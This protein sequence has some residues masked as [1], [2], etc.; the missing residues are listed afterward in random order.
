MTRLKTSMLEA[1]A[2]MALVLIPLVGCS[3][4]DTT[5]AGSGGTTAS[6]G[7]TSSGGDGGTSSTSTGGSGGT[8]GQATGGSGGAA[9]GSGGA[10]GGTSLAEGTYVLNGVVH[11]INNATCQAWGNAYA[12]VGREVLT[13]R[14]DFNVV[15]EA[16]PTAGS[17]S[18]IATAGLV[19][20]GVGEALVSSITGG[21]VVNQWY[22]TGGGTAVVT[23]V[24][25][26][27]HVEAYDIPL[28][29]QSVAGSGSIKITCP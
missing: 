4:S 11:T 21:D 20:P 8:G 1:T 15:F 16:E 23:D 10:G 3:D 29:S 18:V 9:S 7:N 5:P 28:E 17:Y 24:G 13:P 22:A 12:V 14:E 6:G 25:G 19:E 27:I 2:A 26:K